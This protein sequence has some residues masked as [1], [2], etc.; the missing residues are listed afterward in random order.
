MRR[1]RV[2]RLSRAAKGAVAGMGK[3]RDGGGNEVGS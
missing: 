3:G 1:I 2:L